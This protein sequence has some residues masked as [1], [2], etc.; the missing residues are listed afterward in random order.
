MRRNNYQ[1]IYMYRCMRYVGM[2]LCG[3][4]DLC[5][6]VFNSKI[7]SLCNVDDINGGTWIECHKGATT[8]PILNQHIIL[9]TFLPIII[10]IIN[11]CHP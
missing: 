5:M 1:K 6:Y 10:E 8:Y 3:M 4:F 7:R 9:V 11:H 2:W